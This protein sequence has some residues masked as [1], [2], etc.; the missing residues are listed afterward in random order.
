M[1]NL[2]KIMKYTSSLRS[3]LRLLPAKFGNAN[4]RLGARFTMS[5]LICL[6]LSGSVFSS[7]Q[8]TTYPTVFTAKHRQTVAWDRFLMGDF[9]LLGALSASEGGKDGHAVY[10]GSKRLEALRERNYANAEPF[11][12]LMEL[13]APGESQQMMSES[14][15]AGTL[16]I[17]MDFALQ[18]SSETR[19]RQAYG[20]AVHLLHAGIPLK[21]IINP[22]K[23]SRTAN[24]FSASARRLYPTTSTN[25]PRN[26]KAGPIAIFPGFE[27]QAAAVI[28]SYGNGIRVY[29]LQNA[30]TVDVHANLTH[31]PFVFVEVTQNSTIHTSILSAAGL[32]SGTHY[33]TGN[34]T[35][36]DAD[37]CVTIITVPHND[38]IS[39]AQKNAVKAFVRSG[40]NFFAQCAA[41]RG[42][43]ENAPRVFTN[44]GFRD[45]PGVGTFLYDNPQEPSAQF[46]GDI[47]DEGGSL[48]DF[49][50][51]TDPPGGT[52]IVH[53]S[54][55]D[56]K[57]YT[58]RIDGVT[59]SDGGYVH[60]LGGHDHG[61]DID[62]DRYY[63]NAVLRSAIRPTICNLNLGP[64][65]QNDSGTIDCGNGSVTI[66]VLANDTDP[67]G[68]SLTVNL[69]GSGTNGT[70]V[71][72]GNG[73]VTYTG[74]VTGLW[75]G[76]QVT[77]EACNGT[78]C[79]QATI[80]ITG[81]STTTNTIAGTVFNDANNN[82][83]LNG[84]ESGVAGITV[85]LFETGN[86]T[87]VQTTTTT[88]G[89]AY[90]FAVNP[91][92]SCTSGTLLASEDSFTAQESGGDDNFGTCNEL[93]MSSYSGNFDAYTYA[94]FN[95]SGINSACPIV[96]AQFIVTH[97]SSS[98]CWG[99]G[100]SSTPFTFEAR[101]PTGSWTEGGLTWNNQPGNTG[102]YGT[103]TGGRNDA[104]G[105]NYTFD[106]TSLVQGWLNNTITNNG[107]VLVPTG[108]AP[109]GYF[110]F[111]SQE[112][113]AAQGPRLVITY[114]PPAG[115]NNFTVSVLASTL[116]SGATFTT[117]NV[118][119]A[120]F[121]GVGQLDCNNQFGY[122]I[123]PSDNLAVSD[124][125]ICPG[126]TAT[127][128]VSSS[129]VGVSYQLRLDSNNS[130]VGA[131]VAGTGGNI[132]FMVSPSST[133]VYNILATNSSCS[134][135]LTDKPTVTVN[136]VSN[137]GA[138]AANQTICSGQTPAAFTSTTA[139]TGNAAITYQ[140]QI[141]TDNGTSWNNISGATLATYASGALTQTTQFRR[142]AFSG[143]CTPGTPSNVITVTV[144]GVSNAGIIAASQAI[145]SGQTPAAFTSTSAATGAGAITYQWQLSTDNGTSWNNISGATMATYASGPLTQTTQFRR[146]A[147]AG[148]CP[149]AGV[150]SNVITV[151]I[152]GV[153]DAGVIAA[154]QA[155][156]SGQTPAAF[157]ST[158]A[159][160]GTGAITY[161]WQ[162]ST[163]N[164]ANWNNISG[165]TMATYAAGPLTQTTQFRRL[166]FA[167]GC[168]PIGVPSNVVTVTINGVSNAGVIAASQAI[169]SGQTPVAFTSTTAATGTGAIT[170]QW[171]LSTDNGTSWNNISGAT[172]ATYAAGALTQTTQ[173]RRL[174]FAGACPPAGVPSNVVTITVNPNPV[175]SSIVSNCTGGT[176]NSVTVNATVASGTLE[177]SSDGG[178]N[179]QSSNNFTGL[180][181]GVP[182]TFVA[183]LVGT[184][185]TATETYAPAC[186]CPTVT[187]NTIAAS[188]AICSGAVP[189]TLTGLVPTVNPTTPFTY[190]WQ[191]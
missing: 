114:G 67:L 87:P 106:V 166:A 182:Y 112:N 8:A 135:A 72:N 21:W 190:Q 60:Y 154:S 189:A 9:S 148:L 152:N 41:V 168:P 10:F 64:V 108:S 88:A 78:S 127:I 159:A 31:K 26:F 146:L 65:A 111:F 53:D 44:A 185:C 49:G 175:I 54:D 17:A 184:G 47:A 42:F 29:E 68:G 34:L 120:N 119:T 27:T 139:A 71:N 181:I 70:F 95:L 171:Q 25:A 124:A 107:I 11:F 174:A 141:S 4:F 55:N 109:D 83:V 51:N 50:F 105:I 191:V 187:A 118:E 37:E 3:K 147:F 43:Q 22:A 84:G 172:M 19:V 15:P 167:G 2:Y 145:C 73:T 183:R 102:S 93:G 134:V 86:P 137:A 16:I 33:T 28:N 138:I 74:T 150:A 131:P 98:T 153:S 128:T 69:L 57:A 126:Q 136:T 163:D 89:G 92:V 151:T 81:P 117:D 164:G 79:S 20:L 104:S 186:N 143:G 24:D 18:E 96:S 66:N 82:T 129:Q 110:S 162:L 149:P 30:T 62:A 140:W 144:N 177:Y 90:S 58:G 94:R 169:C 188:Q 132:T 32:T 46:E 63:L 12:D 14:L 173:F 7:L 170:Y 38:A 161:Q 76:D 121:T 85:Q 45:T 115:S 1:R 77:Y 180:T 122:R 113:N 130:N 61:G 80:T 6:V 56:F 165:A 101:R 158:T 13:E 35:T 116:P 91:P 103:Q 36:I 52:R 155:I 156:C 125:T 178:T 23:A 179:Y 123:C 48:V 100:G 5:T 59:A 40:G 97:T 39:D 176:L 160:T 142:L 157:T 99:E 133:T 75:S